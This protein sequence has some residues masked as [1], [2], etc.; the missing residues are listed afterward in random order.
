MG[1]RRS[2]RD[3]SVRGVGALLIGSVRLKV[4]SIRIF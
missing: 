4:L 1:S 3:I 2:P